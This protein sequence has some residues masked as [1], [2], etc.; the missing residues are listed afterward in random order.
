M[1]ARSL[2]LQIVIVSVF[3]LDQALAWRKQDKTSA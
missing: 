2:L 3:V 1:L